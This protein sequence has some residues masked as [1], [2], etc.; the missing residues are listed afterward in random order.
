MG[1]SL[2]RERLQRML[3]RRCAAVRRTRRRRPILA[4]SPTTALAL[5]ADVRDRADRRGYVNRAGG[6]RPRRQARAAAR[7]DRLVGADR[8]TRHDARSRP[9]RALLARGAA[10]Q[11]VHARGRRLVVSWP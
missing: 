10:R 9:C 3:C 8:R 5:C 2:T 6:D 7:P 1:G 4:H 11:P